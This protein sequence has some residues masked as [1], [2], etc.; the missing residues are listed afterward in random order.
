[1][2]IGGAIRRGIYPWNR[3]FHNV[4]SGLETACDGCR[5][6][7][8][9][10]ETDRIPGL[11]PRPIT[12]LEPDPVEGPARFDTRQTDAPVSRGGGSQFH[13][14]LDVLEAHPAQV[15]FG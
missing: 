12:R 10:I 1:M 4:Y 6:S 9:P 15:A 13:Y 8:A 2:N 5:A 3:H 14:F 11:Q 7:I